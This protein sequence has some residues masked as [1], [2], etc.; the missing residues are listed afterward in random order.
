MKQR[1]L[2]AASHVLVACSLDAI[3]SATDDFQVVRTVS[4]LTEMDAIVAETPVDVLVL[5]VNGARHSPSMLS[6]LKHRQTGLKIIAV[7]TAGDPAS[8]RSAF[9]LGADGYY[10]HQG[11]AK[12]F[13]GGL[14]RILLATEFAPV[15]VD[16]R[17]ADA[18][19]AA[20]VSISDVA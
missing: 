6:R 5:D 14:R 15:D 7:G 16:R 10:W 3:L 4:D 9:A 12:E 2:V 11:T 19:R 13:A 17:A 8:I 1:V 20:D 18:C